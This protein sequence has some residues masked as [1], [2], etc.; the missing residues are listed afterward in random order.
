[1]GTWLK[2]SNSK[3][4]VFNHD[5]ESMDQ[6]LEGLLESQQP[7]G[8]KSAIITRICEQGSQP[9]HPASTVK[10]IFQVSSKWILHGTTTLQVSSG[11]KLLSTW[12]SHNLDSFMNFFTPS[13]VA[14]VMLP[15]NGI[16]GNVPLL[17]RE[18]FR[19]VHQGLPYSY[20][21]HAQVVQ[22]NVTKFICS[23]ADRLVVR[24]VG[25]LLREFT[26]CIPTE[27]NQV[28]NL[29]LAVLH[30]LSSGVPPPDE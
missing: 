11:F 15:G 30:H 9:T 5:E 29:C 4:Y 19:V 20:T 6:I 16:D 1:M 14:Q 2:R 21:D 24:N 25:L 18:G 10:G 27:E 7:E 26:E 8:V 28:I 17:I 13:F 23:T 22:K 3:K 12:G